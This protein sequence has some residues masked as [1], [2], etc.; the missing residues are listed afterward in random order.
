MAPQASLPLTGGS[1]TGQGEKVTGTGKFGAMNLLLERYHAVLG[2][3]C[4]A[5]YSVCCGIFLL[6][7]LR[8]SKPFNAYFGGTSILLCACLNAVTAYREYAK[9]V[10]R[11]RAEEHAATETDSISEKYRDEAIERTSA[12]MTGAPDEEARLLIEV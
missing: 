9:A 3:V 12:E 1:V 6:V 5:I 7:T 8:E 10:R 11:V 4:C 2:F